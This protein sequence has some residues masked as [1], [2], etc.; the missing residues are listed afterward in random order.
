[1]RRDGRAGT[2]FRRD[3]VDGGDVF[4][5]VA[6]EHVDRNDRSAAVDLHV[7]KLL[8]QVV[9]AL[10]DLVGVCL[11][12]GR[13]QW[14]ARDDAMVAGV[15]LEAADGRHEH[16]RVRSET[17]VAA[18]DVEESLG[19]HVGAEAGLG[20]QEVAR[21]DPDSVGHDRAVAGGNVAEGAGVHESG[22]VLERLHQVWFDRLPQDDGHRSGCADVFGGDGLTGLCVAE[23]DAAHAGSQVEQIGRERQRGHDF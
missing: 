13:G 20:Q 12:K 18:L 10:V 1:M 9:A 5:V 15:G 14:L 2:V 11:E 17:R 3:L 19:A 16:R 23:H 7:L 21:V 22:G 8:A 6:G 4:V